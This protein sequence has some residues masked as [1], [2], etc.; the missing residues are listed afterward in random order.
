MMVRE[1]AMIFTGGLENALHLEE[2]L[3]M[4]SILN[5]II[6]TET[7]RTS[8][9]SCFSVHWKKIPALAFSL[10]EIQFLG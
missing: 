8:N 3:N 6:L 10:V 4:Y 9:G 5:N 2:M 1:K 7:L